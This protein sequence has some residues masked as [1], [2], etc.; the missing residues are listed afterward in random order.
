MHKYTVG[1]EVSLQVDDYGSWGNGSWAIGNVV[2]C[3]FVNGK[4]AYD[5][6]DRQGYIIRNVM[7][8]FK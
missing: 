6:Q 1:Q 3:I 8:E 4:P 5:I 7:E 2:A